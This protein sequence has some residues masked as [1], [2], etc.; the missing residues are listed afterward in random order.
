MLLHTLPTGE[1]VFRYQKSIVIPFK[2]KRHVLSTAYLNGGYQE[3]LKTV[4]N[5][6]VNPGAGMACSLRADTYQEHMKLITEEIGLDPETTAGI[7]TA[8]SMENVSIKTAEF[9]ELKVTAIVTGGIEVN[10]G[11]VGDPTI[12]HEIDNKTQ[13]I[14]EGTINIILYING[15]LPPETMTRSLVTC[16]EA[17][18]AAIQE[19]MIGSQY[20]RGLATGSGTDGTIIV[21]NPESQY[22]YRFAGKHSKLGELIGL[23]VKSAVKEAL[24]LQTGVNPEQQFSVL[25]RLQRFGINQEIIWGAYQQK[26]ALNKP[27]FVC[28]LEEIDK[29]PELV[30]LTSLYAHLMDQLD[31]DLLAPDQVIQEG[32][33]ILKRMLNQD[34]IDIS[35]GIAGV[36]KDEAIQMMTEQMVAGLVELVKGK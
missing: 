21:G 1:H 35:V 13:Q 20:S 14:K 16:T 31:W 3:D 6:D 26:Y 34:E 33:V 30:L 24:Y 17:K 4:F 22:T 10:G 27:E 2:G 18:T 7:T 8:A 29:I 28:R 25:R 9:R 19:L 32:V 12:W 11:R 36:S 23:A 15:N 5:H